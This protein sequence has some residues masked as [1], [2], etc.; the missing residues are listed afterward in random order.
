VGRVDR[1]AQRADVVCCGRRLRH[2]AVLTPL[3]KVADDLH[4]GRSGRH[5]GL[6]RRGELVRL[7]RCVHAR[8]VPV[9]RGEE[10]SGGGHDRMP[11][12]RGAREPEG[13]LAAASGI[14]DHGDTPGGVFLQPRGAVRAVREVRAVP[15]NGDGRMRVR[16]DEPGQR[17]PAGQ[18]LQVTRAGNHA[19]AGKAVQ[20]HP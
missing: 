10:T 4:P 9:G 1:L 17:E 12:R 7:D 15:V 20:E 3:R 19:F 5:L 6:D 2:R 8:K 18:F 11:G 14:A 16:I 13:D